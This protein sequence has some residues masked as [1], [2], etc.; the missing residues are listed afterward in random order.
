MPGADCK[1][2]CS[3]CAAAAA[4][5]LPDAVCAGD[6]PTSGRQH[7]QR[8]WFQQRHRLQ[9][10]FRQ[11]CAAGINGGAANKFFRTLNG[12]AEFACGGIE[13]A[14]CL[15]H[16]FGADAVAGQNCNAMVAGHILQVLCTA[17]VDCLGRQ[18]RSAAAVS[19]YESGRSFGKR[20]IGVRFYSRKPETC[21]S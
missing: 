13:Y 14:E 3:A 5:P 21:G 7:C 18:F 6:D 16:N 9:L 11:R 1:R 8:E 10:F 15:A 2:A 12:K 19:I 17:A 4:P 20:A